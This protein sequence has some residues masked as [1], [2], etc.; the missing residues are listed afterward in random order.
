M[1]LVVEAFNRTGLPLVVIGDGPE[2]ARLE[3]MARPNVR[4]LGRCGSR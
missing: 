4:F 3:A 2:R 1:D